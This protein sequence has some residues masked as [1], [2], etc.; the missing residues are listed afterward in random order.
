MPNV[1]YLHGF[2]SGP[3]SAKGRF[4][5]QNFSIIGTDLHQPDLA[6]GDFRALT[7]TGQLKAVDRAV[8]D[9]DPALIIGSSLGGYL[10][11]LYAAQKP[12]NVR[13]LVLLAPAFGFAKRWAD[14]LG[15]AEMAEWKRT[16]ERRVYHYGMQK[17]LPLGYQFFED[18]LW[19]EEFPAVTQPTLMFHGRYDDVVNPNLS[20]EYA[21]GK[22]N[23]ELELLD[24]D[25]QLLDVLDPIWERVAEFYRKVEPHDG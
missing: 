8:R 19:H 14:E 9:L 20:I 7:I 10:A 13:R 6:E 25:H 1:L 21:W 11:A 23:A 12:D 2:A 15:E 18:A 16:G 22:D 4:F 5:H 17:M 3:E 24:S